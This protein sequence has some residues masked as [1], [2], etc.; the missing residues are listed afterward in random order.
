[1]A[2]FGSR[3]VTPQEIQAKE[4]SVARFNGYKMR[5][6]DEFLDQITETLTGVLA[7]N[8]RLRTQSGAAPVVG[9]PDLDDVSR[10]ADEIIQRAREE[11]ARIVA[12]AEERAASTA[13]ASV[14]AGS[15]EAR[16]AV[17]AFLVRERAFLQSLA[18]LVQ[19]H[20]ESVKGMA[21]QARGTHQ[22]RSEPT[23]ASEPGEAS[24]S[25]ERAGSAGPPEPPAS[26]PDR[27]E[28]PSAE[29]PEPAPAADP[30]A[31]QALPAAE[32]P[33]RVDEPQ[34]VPTD[35]EGDPSL[36]ELFWGEES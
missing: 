28:R 36:R 3:S 27:G 8:E 26:T 12:E 11:A 15:E 4:F 2:G 33:V 34:P 24:E 14:V 25:S 30:E 32:R 23:P 35:A 19:D 21:R 31:T 9:A 5:D 17:N 18:A 16:A 10:Q 6:V 1:M 20:A 29:A 7:E 13:G 22:P